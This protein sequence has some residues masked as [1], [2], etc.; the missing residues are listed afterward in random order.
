MKEDDVEEG[1][2]TYNG[3]ARQAAEKEFDWTVVAWGCDAA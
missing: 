1:K 2:K 3:I